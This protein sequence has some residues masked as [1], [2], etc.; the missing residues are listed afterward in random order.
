MTKT[1]NRTD[2]TKYSLARY[3]I[4]YVVTTYLNHRFKENGGS[5]SVFEVNEAAEMRQ[6]L[7]EIL[8]ACKKGGYDF[9]FFISIAEDLLL[10]DWSTDRPDFYRRC[11]PIIRFIKANGGFSEI[12]YR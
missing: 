4:S 11:A 10:V 5:V 1:T 8:D 6:K 12:G 3:D 9:D 7:F 2:K